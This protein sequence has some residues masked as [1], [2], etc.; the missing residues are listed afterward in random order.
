MEAELQE[1]VESSC[2][3]AGRVVDIYVNLKNT[4]DQL[5]KMHSGTGER[6]FWMLMSELGLM[7]A[8]VLSLFRDYSGS[9][10]N[11]DSPLVDFL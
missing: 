2:K 10:H 4:V 8:V 11:D 3:Q 7:V 5:K 9:N 6:H 1:R